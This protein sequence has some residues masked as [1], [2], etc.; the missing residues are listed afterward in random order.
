MLKL[1]ITVHDRENEAETKETRCAP[2]ETEAN[3]Q[4]KQTRE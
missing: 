1:N 3:Q 4:A 2:N